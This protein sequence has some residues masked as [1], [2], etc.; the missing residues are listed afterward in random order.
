MSTLKPWNEEGATDEEAR[1]VAAMK[2][3][4]AGDAA[5]A[6]T[7]T[8]LG[9]GAA[10]LG[11]AAGA[12]TGKT[13]LPLAAK[14]LAALGVVGIGAAVWYA[15]RPPPA[16]GVAIPLAPVASA[17]ASIAAP[18]VAPVSPASIAVDDLPRAAPVRS[19]PA[20]A[21][22]TAPAEGSLSRELAALDRAKRALA[23]GDGPGALRELDD[24]RRDFANGD[25]A[26]EEV[27]LRVRT[28][29]AMGERDRARALADGF[30]AEHPSSPYA[31]RVHALVHKE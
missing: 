1:L 16:R 25:L 11:A 23:N 27:V 29:L 6:R 7:L 20:V 17:P 19:A 28:L 26:P 10:S 5:R 31:A 15:A 8:A 24:Y 12:T 3:E 13:W 9:L 30:E 14:W 2:T 21:S 22:T 4:T 18:V